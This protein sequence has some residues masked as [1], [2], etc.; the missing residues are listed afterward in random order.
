MIA[1]LTV[2]CIER[3]SSPWYREGELK[4]TPANSLSWGGRADSPGKPR[5]L[6]FLDQSTRKERAAPRKTSEIR[7]GSPS[8][9]QQ[10]SDQII[11]VRK[12]VEAVERTTGLEGMVPGTHIGL[13]TVPVATSQTESLKI[14]GV[15][16]RALTQVFPWLQGITHPRLGTDLDLPNKSSKQ[17]LERSS[18]FQVT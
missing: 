15:R 11:C 18:R 13:G 17:E 12:I 10:S 6:K 7:R 16:G 2:F 5:Q 3:D 9:T 4:L 1:Q 8:S 14:H